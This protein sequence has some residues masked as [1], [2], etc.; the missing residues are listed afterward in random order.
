[1]LIE[2]KDI[3]KL[4]EIKIKNQ[5]KIE[6]KTKLSERLTS[7]Y[8]ELDYLKNK[9]ENLNFLS[10][11]LSEYYKEARENNLKE[12][13]KVI[14]DTMSYI[15]GKTYDVN[16]SIKKQGQYDYLDINVNGVP[17]KDLSGGEKQVLSLLLVAES[18]TDEVLILDETIN[19]LD[20]FTQETILTYLNDLSETYQII[21]IELDDN[22]N[23]QYDYIVDE[24][25][26]QIVR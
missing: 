8:Q 13:S 24:G 4:K 2:L 21:M 18:V 5:V 1:M 19:S 23:I 9:Y 7:L 26:V 16:I 22:L 20:P 17:Q 25:G 3:N 12:L 11:S 14:G 6:E 10:T 15:L